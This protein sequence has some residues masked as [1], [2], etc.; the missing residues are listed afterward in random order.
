[1]T[2]RDTSRDHAVLEAQ[3]QRSNVYA[4][5]KIKWGAP[6]GSM[7]GQWTPRA[8]RKPTGGLG[9]VTLGIFALLGALAVALWLG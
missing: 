7:R 9:L 4:F 6:R 1:M 2:D 3:R 8:E 5:R